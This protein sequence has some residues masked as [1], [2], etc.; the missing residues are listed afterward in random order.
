MRNVSFMA[1]AAVLLASAVQAQGLV[2]LDTVRAGHE[3][4]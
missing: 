2:D 4:I 1:V 3:L